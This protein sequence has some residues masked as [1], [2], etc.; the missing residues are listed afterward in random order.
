[1]REGLAKLG[2]IEGRHLRIDL[3]FTSSDPDR[4]RAYAVEL[5]SPAPEVIV[6]TS[7]PAT[8]AAQEQTQTIPIVFTAGNDPVTNGLLQNTARPEGNTTGFSSTVD[9][10]T[11]KWLE[12]LKE[13]APHITRVALVFNPR[14]SMSVISARSRRPRPAVMAKTRIAAAPDIPTVDEA[15][16]PGFYMSA[17]QAIWAP[18]GTP[19]GA[20]GTLNAAIVEALADPVVRAR[21][22]DLGQETVPPEQQSAEALGALQKAEIE[23]WW[24]IIKA[25]NIKAE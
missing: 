12:L 20:I 7:A 21:L 10:L 8:R 3:R 23:R 2:W 25:A 22:G 13:A 9:S 15:G 19:K 11:G 17:W 6:T 4:M 24:P 14:R 18:K 16:L 1:L 5:V